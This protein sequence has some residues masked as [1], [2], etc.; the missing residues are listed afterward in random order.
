[1]NMEE[2]G[3]VDDVIS[4]FN[5][6]RHLFENDGNDKAHMERVMAVLTQDNMEI[7]EK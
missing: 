6:N 7:L 4:Y 2:V 3:T 5:E 1:M